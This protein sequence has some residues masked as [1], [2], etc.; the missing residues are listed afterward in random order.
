M[1]KVI[2]LKKFNHWF[3]CR[4]EKIEQ[5]KENN[6]LKINSHCRFAI[7]K[8]KQTLAKHTRLLNFLLLLL[9]YYPS[10]FIEKEKKE[11]GNQI[12]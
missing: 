4:E 5:R 6:K 9:L 2:S 12:K 7:D 10:C 8:R 1:G 3:L 11:K